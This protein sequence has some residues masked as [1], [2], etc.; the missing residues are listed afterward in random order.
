M[1]SS[2]LRMA[3]FTYLADDMLQ[4]V[5]PLLSVTS[6]SF[7]PRYMSRSPNHPGFIWKKLSTHLK[8]DIAS[9]EIARQSSTYNNTYS[10]YLN[11]S[12]SHVAG[13]YHRSGLALHASKPIILMQSEMCLPN[14]APA[15]FN[16]Y[17]AW[18]MIAVLSLSAPNSGP[19]L[20]YIFSG[21]GIVR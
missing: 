13:L 1:Y 9:C 15:N 11:L 19:N 5:T 17:R 7:T 16:P 18:T 8:T 10:Y 4:H 2:T 3:S 6:L 12:S 20:V 21:N 14:D